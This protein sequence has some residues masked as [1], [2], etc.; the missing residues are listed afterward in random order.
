MTPQN[1]TVVYLAYIQ[2]MD[3]NFGIFGQLNKTWTGTKLAT[4]EDS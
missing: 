3:C 2:R 4:N 1:R